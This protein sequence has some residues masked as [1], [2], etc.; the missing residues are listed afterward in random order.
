MNKKTSLI[1]LLVSSAVV[2]G[3]FCFG[4]RVGRW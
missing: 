4:K 3:V 1:T 2:A